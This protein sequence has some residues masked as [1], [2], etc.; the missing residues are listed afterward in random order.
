[1]RASGDGLSPKEGPELPMEGERIP[2]RHGCHRY[3]ISELAEVRLCAL[4]S[5][6]TSTHRMSPYAYR[7]KEYSTESQ[8]SLNPIFL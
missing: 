3:A 6:T 1:M 8:T 2:I 7:E 5:K 4:D